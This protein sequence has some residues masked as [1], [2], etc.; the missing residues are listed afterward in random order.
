[1]L[2]ACHALLY[3]NF[4]L[5]A[6]ALKVPVQA[7]RKQWKRV[8]DR[9]KKLSQVSGEI[10]PNEHIWSTPYSPQFVP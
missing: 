2:I 5:E 1:M 8:H 4:Y 9:V 7:V 6:A 3:L 10:T